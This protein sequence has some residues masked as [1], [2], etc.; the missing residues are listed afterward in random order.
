MDSKSNASAMFDLVDTIDVRNIVK[1]SWAPKG[2]ASTAAL[3]LPLMAV[4]ESHLQAGTG[5][6]LV[7]TAHLNFKIVIPQVLYLQVGDSGPVA[8][9]SNG[10]NV[11][12]TATVRA[13]STN[14]AHGNVILSAAARKV[15]AQQAVCAASSSASPV[16]CT[17]SL[18]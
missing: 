16:L 3:L 14:P 5:A 8:I 6:A 1:C 2:V 15:I 9:M 7:A 11:A 12:L 17:A 10:R 13:P 18:P 4:A